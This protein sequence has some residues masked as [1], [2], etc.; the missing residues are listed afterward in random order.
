MSD[1]ST[2]YPNLNWEQFAICNDNR[3]DAFE[4][5]CRDL[6]Y[7]E[8]LNEV[9]NPHS[10]HNNPGVEVLPMLEPVRDDGLPQKYISFQAKYFE[11]KIK[12]EQITASLKKAVEHFEGK[13]GRIYLF[14]NKVIS[15]NSNRYIK[16]QD[17]LK[18][19]GVELELVTDKDIFTLIRKNIRVANYFFQDRKRVATGATNLMDSTPVLSSVTDNLSE[20]DQTATNPLLNKFVKYGIQKCKEAVYDL[21][22]GILKKSWVYLVQR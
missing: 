19:Y 10:D 17:V 3:T 7:C 9:R 14:C 4:D 1:Q 5:M 11:T 6:F 12:D 2:F 8:Y 18:D 22:F 13:L 21:Q 15:K 16:Y 20:N